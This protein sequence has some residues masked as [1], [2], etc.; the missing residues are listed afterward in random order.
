MKT[1]RNSRQLW[2]GASVALV[3]LSM[4]T[5]AVAQRS[6]ANR[7]GR[8]APG[9]GD[10]GPEMR[11][12]RLTK[13]LDL[14]ADQ[15][16]AIGEIHAQSRA[17]S[18]DLRKELMRLRHEKSGELLKDDPADKTVLDLTKKIG[19]LRTQVQTNRTRARLEVRKVLTP[20]QRDKMLLRG[21]GRRHGR[22]LS[23]GGRHGGERGH[24]QRSGRQGCRQDCR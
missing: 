2:V 5:I 4:A 13:H 23:D 16:T 10:F 18:Q 21:E 6:G 9:A 20:E 7:P 1:R 24:G 14:T 11:L 17:K 12:E 22:D 3:I 15:A 8:G 19:D